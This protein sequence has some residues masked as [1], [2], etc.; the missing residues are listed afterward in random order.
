MFKSEAEA[1]TER[2][3]FAPIMREFELCVERLPANVRNV[4][5]ALLS[6]FPV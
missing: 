4:S 1:Q 2:D 5:K 3:H 6:A